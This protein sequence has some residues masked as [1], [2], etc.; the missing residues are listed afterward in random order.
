[1]YRYIYVGLFFLLLCC[2]WSCILEIR[3]EL[4]IREKCFTI[5]LL[6]LII[7]VCQNF[8][9]VYIKQNVLDFRFYFHR[10]EY[11]SEMIS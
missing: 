10:N 8:F 11:R 2:L 6:F 1:M 9:H 7:K 5:K 4:H 3:K